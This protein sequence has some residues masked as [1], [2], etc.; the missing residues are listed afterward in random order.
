MT[1]KQRAEPWQDEVRGALAIWGMWQRSL[2]G[3]VHARAGL[4]ACYH[5][6]V[7]RETV[8]AQQNATAEAMDRVMCRVRQASDSAY[9]VLCLYYIGDENVSIRDIAD[10]LKVSRRRVED[11]KRQGEA[12][13]SMLWRHRIAA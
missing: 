7:S 1:S 6:R 2:P 3:G 11:L 4:V 5:E 8:T 12:M 13:A 9:R 10:A